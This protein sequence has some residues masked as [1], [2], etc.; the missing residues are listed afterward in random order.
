VPRTTD[1]IGCRLPKTEAAAV[2]R[3]A[4]ARGITLRAVIR[5]ALEP[6]IALMGAYRD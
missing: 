5:E 6:H 4:R 1:M 2:R 3:Y